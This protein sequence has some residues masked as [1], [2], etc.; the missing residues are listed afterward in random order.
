MFSSYLRLT[1]FAPFVIASKG[2]AVSIATGAIAGRKIDATAPGVVSVGGAWPRCWGQCDEGHENATA[3]LPFG[4]AVAVHSKPS[5]QPRQ[6]GEDQSV[7]Q[8]QQDQRAGEQRQPE[9][10]KG[11]QRPCR[12]AA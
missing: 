1:T 4:K 10:Q 6:K 8:S 2:H 11:K 5:R 7:E 12:N 3:I 9:Q